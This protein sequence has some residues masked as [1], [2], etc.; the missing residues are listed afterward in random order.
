MVYECRQSVNTNDFEGGIWIYDTECKGVHNTQCVSD[1]WFYP[2][3][4]LIHN[5]TNQYIIN[6]ELN[7]LYM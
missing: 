5:Q 6:N 1:T 2:E 3:Q 4:K 7:V